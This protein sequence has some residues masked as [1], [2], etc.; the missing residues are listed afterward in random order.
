MAKTATKSDRKPVFILNGPNL[1]MLGKRE[2]EKYGRASLADVQR[3]TVEAGTRLGL[4]VDFRQSNSEGE[5]VG[6]SIEGGIEHGKLDPFVV[7]NALQNARHDFVATSLFGRC[8]VHLRQRLPS[9]RDGS[10]WSASC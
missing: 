7:A 3:L 2:P 5:L 10:L 9:W 1:N 4:G 8:W 6:W